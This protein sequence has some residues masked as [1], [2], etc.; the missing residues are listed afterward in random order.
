MNIASYRSAIYV[1]AMF[2]L[3]L[4]LTMLIPMVA[5]LYTGHRDWQAF[6]FSALSA[7]GSLPQPRLP[8]VSHHPP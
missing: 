6:A 5:D 1:A 3:Y 8:R 2:G 7:A 4:S